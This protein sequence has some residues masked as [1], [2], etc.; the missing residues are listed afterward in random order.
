MPTENRRV[1]T[2]LP[3]VIDDRLEAFKTERGLKGDSPALVAI[4]EEFFGVS[5][6]VAH[7]SE[8]EVASLSKQV[9]SLID[10]VA[11]LEGELLG[12]LKSSPQGDLKSELLGEL[13]GEL[14]DRLKPDLKS[15]L[16][17]ELRSELLNTSSEISIASG[18]LD[19]IPADQIEQNAIPISSSQSELIN[20]SLNSDLNDSDTL[21]STPGESE[22]EL[23][24]KAE[25][26]TISESASWSELKGELLP[27]TEDDLAKRFRLTNPK[28]LANKRSQARNDPQAFIEWSIKKDPEDKP[29]LYDSERKQYHRVAQQLSSESEDF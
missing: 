23:P 21:S 12:E 19:L 26:E 16:L 10:K 8:S 7:F 1:A 22:S 11:H 5:Q 29:W 17:S 24:D 20:E 27:M 25:Q 15:E 13:Q 9:E 2:Y 3:K 6:E 14:F 18:Q 4:L 28:S